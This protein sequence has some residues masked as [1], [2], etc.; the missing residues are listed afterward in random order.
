MNDERELAGALRNVCAKLLDAAI[1]ALLIATAVV[2]VSGSMYPLLCYTRLWSKAVP[3][4]NTLLQFGFYVHNRRRT[5]GDAFVHIEIAAD[6]KE[7][8]WR[9]TAFIRAVCASLMFSPH[10]LPGIS[11][12]AL[13]AF[14]LYWLITGRCEPG[15]EI[16][17]DYAARTTALISPVTRAGRGE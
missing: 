4:T 14:T 10:W 5:L 13:W 9:R 11:T 3:I 2:G 7:S 1:A 16:A 8:S 15:K 12:V 6:D 17:W